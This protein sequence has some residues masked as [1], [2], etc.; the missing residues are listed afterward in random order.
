MNKTVVY[1]K[2]KGSINVISSE[3]KVFSLYKDKI[4]LMKIWDRRGYKYVSIYIDGKRKTRFVHRLVAECFFDNFHDNGLEVNH[5]NRDKSDNCVENL[6]MVTKIENM[7]HYCNPDGNKRLGA[8]F[9]PDKKFKK[10]QARI[11]YKGKTLSLKYHLTREEAQEAYRKK[12]FEIHGVE[13]WL[14]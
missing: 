12:F 4:S 9:H 7:M 3:G 2:I 5:K 11:N 1:K 8:I 10:W 13:P 14:I 6:E